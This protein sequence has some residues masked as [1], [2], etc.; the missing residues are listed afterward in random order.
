VLLVIAL[1]TLTA[2]ESG[3]GPDKPASTSAIQSAK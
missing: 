2:C 3:K 1:A